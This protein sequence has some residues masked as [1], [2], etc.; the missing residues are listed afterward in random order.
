MAPPCGPPWIVIVKVGVHAAVHVAGLNTNVV[1]VSG[2]AKSTIV[3]VPGVPTKL[4]R[5][6]DTVPV[7]VWDA[8]TGRMRVSVTGLIAVLKFAVGAAFVSI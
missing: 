5:V 3:T 2:A 7:P 1:P 6:T 4:D 8:K